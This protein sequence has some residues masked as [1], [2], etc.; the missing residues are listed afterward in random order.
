MQGLA[1][2]SSK[3]VLLGLAGAAAAHDRRRL[4]SSTSDEPCMKMTLYWHD[5]LYDGGNNTANA[6]SAGATK[7]TALS[8][9]S[10][11]NGTFFGLLVVFDDP[12]TT[13]EALPVAGEEPA[14]RGQG[15]YFYNKKDGY[16]GWFGFSIVFDSP[17]HKD[18][19]N[20]VGA[21]LMEEETHDLTV[22]GGTG[23][24]FMARG[25][26]TIRLDAYEGTTYTRIQMD[27][28]LYECYV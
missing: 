7:P 16:N 25:I 2:A 5:I 22:V 13:G 24:F 6:T 11:K 27:I 17:A 10:W 8:T 14:A 12:M 15:F 20:L 23:D 26:T 1:V 9:A 19:L 3:I 4:V 28:K 18:T 21:D